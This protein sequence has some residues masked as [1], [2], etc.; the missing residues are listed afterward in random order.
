M[1]R[2]ILGF[3]IRAC[4]HT[5]VSEPS[6]ISNQKFRNKILYSLN[7]TIHSTIKNLQ[8]RTVFFDHLLE[9]LE[10]L[11]GILFPSILIFSTA[12]CFVIFPI[13]IINLPGIFLSNTS[14]FR[15]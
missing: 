2:S 6:K 14:N 13:S 1:R 8:Y 4:S 7:K 9:F 15:M 3:D 12:I 10:T 11:E 5:I